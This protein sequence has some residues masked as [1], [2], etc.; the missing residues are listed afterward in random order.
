MQ[1]EQNQSYKNFDEPQI[2]RKNAILNLTSRIKS[3][4]NSINSSK[5]ARNSDHKNIIRNSKSDSC[6]DISNDFKEL[7]KY[8]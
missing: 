3:Q 1:N 7:P 4:K 5:L 8:K 6:D 2:P